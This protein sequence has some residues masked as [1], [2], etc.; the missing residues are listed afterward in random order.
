VAYKGPISAIIHQMM[1]GLRSSMGYTGCVNIDEM[2]SK[3]RF[4]RITSAGI[5]ESH[6]HD[7]TITKEAPNYRSE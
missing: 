7:V 3:P 1:G 4:V 2:R 6:V 5:K